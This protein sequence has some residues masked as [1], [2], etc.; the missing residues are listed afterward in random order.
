MIC[1][2]K[3]PCQTVEIIRNK[4]FWIASDCTPKNQPKTFFF[5]VDND[6]IYEPFFSDFG[7]L[8][9][10]KTCKFALEVEKLLHCSQFANCKLY[11]HTALDECKKANSAFLMGAFQILVLGKTAEESWEP[12]ENSGISFAHFRDA[13]MGQCTFKCSILDCLKGLEY[14]VRLKWISLRKFDIKA[15]EHYEKVENGDLNWIVPGK[16]VAFSGPSNV[17]K[18][19]EGYKRLVP[20]DY[21]SI[22]KKF[23]IKLVIRLNHKEYDESIFKKYG[24]KHKDF[25]FPDN[26]CPSDEL[27]EEFI[28]TCEEEKGAIA[29]H[30]KAGLGRT[31]TVIACYVMKHYKFPAKCLIGWT[32]LCRPGSIL[33][34]QQQFLITKE[35]HFHQLAKTSPM[36]CS[37]QP[38]NMKESRKKYDLCAEEA[39]PTIQLKF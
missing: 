29:V 27:L 7:P 2:P 22:F 1:D 25:C 5:N 28:K 4:L 8:D 19:E 33:G 17:S 15:Y 31:G 32:R 3:N 12:F 14:A 9:L 36:Y 13:S 16:F 18:D 10:G 38:D 39:K 34:K 6:L 11:H 20:E 24:I 21:I 37:L 23:N 26:S 35:P 30:C